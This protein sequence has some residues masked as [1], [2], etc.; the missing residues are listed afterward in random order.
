[1]CEVLLVTAVK[2]RIDDTNPF[3]DHH[4]TIQWKGG[5]FDHCMFLIF[6]NYIAVE[7]STENRIFVLSKQHLYEAWWCN[8][9]NLL[10]TTPLH[11]FDKKP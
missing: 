3:V 10:T 4:K 7:T 6:S 8:S 2:R 5:P 9:F 1:M 11:A